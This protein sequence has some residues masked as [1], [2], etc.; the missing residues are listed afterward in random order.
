[1]GGCEGV[2]ATWR[3]AETTNS[4]DVVID[5]NDGALVY[6]EAELPPSLK[7]HLYFI[8]RYNT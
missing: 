8:S 1:M 7:E 6:S 2:L 3:A 4:V 5:R